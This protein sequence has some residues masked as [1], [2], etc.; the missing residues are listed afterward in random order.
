MRDLHGYD[1]RWSIC[2]HTLD[3]GPNNFVFEFLIL[4]IK[5]SLPE[6]SVQLKCVI[7][8]IKNVFISLFNDYDIPHQKKVVVI[9]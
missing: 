9:F 2:P 7:Y 3:C 5:M 8:Y 6:V 4:V 1:L